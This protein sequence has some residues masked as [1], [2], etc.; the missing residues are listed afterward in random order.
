MVERSRSFQ[1][2]LAASGHLGSRC[3]PSTGWGGRSRDSGSQVLLTPGDRKLIPSPPPLWMAGFLVL[4]LG[5]RLWVS[6][7]VTAL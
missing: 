7:P 3:S 6:W 5:T 4:P 2:T 1:V